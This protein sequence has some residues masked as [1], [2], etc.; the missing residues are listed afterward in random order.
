MASE[1]NNPK[2]KLK[3]LID[4]KSQRVLLAEAG[5]DAVDFLFTLLTLPLGS[6]ITLITKESMVGSLG[7]T[8]GSLEQLDNGYFLSTQ[9]KTSILQNKTGPIYCISC[10]YIA[11]ATSYLHAYGFPCLN[12]SKYSK[13]SGGYVIGSITY[14]I[15]DDLSVVPMTPTSTIALLN[16]LGL[17]DFKLLEEKTVDMCYQEVFF[18]ISSSDKY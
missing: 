12:C 11:P 13:K 3:L 14:S 4:K 18:I 1:A 15:M 5:K 6:L 8:Y 17:N 16:Q 9:S 10:G 2:I 7:F